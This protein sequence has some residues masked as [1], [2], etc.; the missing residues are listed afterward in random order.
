MHKVEQECDL[1]IKAAKE[2]CNIKAR[3]PAFCPVL[4]ALW[5]SEGPSEESPLLGNAVLKFLLQYHTHFKEEGTRGC[6]ESPICSSHMTLERNKVQTQA[7]SH[8]ILCNYILH[9]NTSQ[10]RNFGI[11]L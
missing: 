11:I 5:T 4:V 6:E 8:C 7:V 1:K 2:T 10:I 9:Y 3:I